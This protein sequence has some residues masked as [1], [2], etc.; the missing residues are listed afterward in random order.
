MSLAERYII[1]PLVKIFEK[2]FER[3]AEKWNEE[4]KSGIYNI[5]CLVSGKYYIG[6]SNTIEARL[7]S[8]KSALRNN[9]HVNTH[10]QNAFNLYGEENFLFLVQEYTLSDKEIFTEREQ[11]WVDW[12]GKENVYNIREI[13]DSNLGLKHSEQSRFNMSAG[14]KNRYTSEEEVQKMAEIL[15]PYSFK[16]GERSNIEGEYKPDCTPWNKGTKG[17]MKSNKTSWVPQTPYKF[18]SPDNIEYSGDDLPAFAREHNLTPTRLYRV[19]NGSELTHRGWTTPENKLLMSK[20]KCKEYTFISPEGIM[21]KTYNIK[22]LASEFGLNYTHMYKV[23]HKSY[24]QH[25]GWKLPQEGII[26]DQV[27]E[28]NPNKQGTI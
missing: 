9:C 3:T 24:S 27:I 12:Y 25:K 18:I 20:P 26:Y 6:Q 2:S 19:L 15:K 22:Y 14:Q 16:K 4:N 23:Y 17:I 10:L 7:E 28:F 21:Y 5:Q 13:V 11:F 8:H 1:N